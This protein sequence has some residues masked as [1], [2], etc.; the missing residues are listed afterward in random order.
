MDSTFEYVKVAKRGKYSTGRFEPGLGTG[1]SSSE[2]QQMGIPFGSAGAR[3][4][5]L[6][7]T[8]QIMKRLFT[9]ETI[10][11][12]GKYYTITQMKGY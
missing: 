7:E 2:F 12:T 11:F 6:A 8:L 10:S 3:V 1:V 9:D 4:E 5:Q